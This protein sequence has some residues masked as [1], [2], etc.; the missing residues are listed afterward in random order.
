VT[1]SAPPPASSAPHPG[2]QTG[3]EFFTEAEMQRRE[4]ENL[5]AVLEKAGWKIKGPDGAAELMG[6]K[7]TT[8]L[9]RMK[10]MGLA[11]PG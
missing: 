4:R 5:V 8:L 10:K 9:S 3:L 7:P 6:L 11:R 2:P 1:D